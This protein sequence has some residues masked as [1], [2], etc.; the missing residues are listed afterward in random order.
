ME[1]TAKEKIIALINYIESI[2][3]LKEKIS[4][5][6]I[7]IDIF[8]LNEIIEL[9]SNLNNAREVMMSVIKRLK[10]NEMVEKITEE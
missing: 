10:Q 2:N 7:L 3:N 4:N 9:I 5:I 6:D 8:T 1:Y